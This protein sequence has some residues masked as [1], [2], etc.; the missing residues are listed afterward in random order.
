MQRNIYLLGVAAAALAT[1]A[2]G[3][4]GGG[5]VLGGEVVLPGQTVQIISPP[6]EKVTA[7]GGAVFNLSATAASSTKTLAEM[8]WSVTTVTP[9]APQMVLTDPNCVSAAKN[10]LG[11]SINSSTWSCKTSTVAP[12]SLKEA[13]YQLLVTATDSSGASAHAVH[14]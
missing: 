14:Y 2:A 12:A 4:G 13:T 7:R 5:E 11:G 6:P 8:K 1:L 9:G 10:D 3:C